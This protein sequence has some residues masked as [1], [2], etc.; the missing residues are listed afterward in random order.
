MPDEIHPRDKISME[1]AADYLV[2]LI[3]GYT[4][5]L[6][7]GA[8]AI[9]AVSKKRYPGQALPHGKI[10]HRQD[11]SKLSPALQQAIKDFRASQKK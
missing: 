6:Q 8:D 5:Q 3:G 1:G 4:V 10:Y 11:A 9:Y 2:G 7:G